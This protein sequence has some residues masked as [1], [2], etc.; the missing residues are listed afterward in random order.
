[1]SNTWNIRTKKEPYVGSTIVLTT[2]SVGK[3]KRIFD[4]EVHN[5]LRI[6]K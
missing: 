6:N 2:L 5:E 1:V 4:K 3:I